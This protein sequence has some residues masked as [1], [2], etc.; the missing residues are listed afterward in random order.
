M[1]SS[2]AAADYL[3]V[4]SSDPTFVR[5]QALNAGAR[6][7]LMAG[8]T[9]TVM[10]AS[11]DVVTLKAAAG[12]ISLPQRVASAP[13]ADRMAVLRFILAPAPRENGPRPARTRGGICPSAEA[14]STLDAIAQVQ[15]GGCAD[16][17]AKALEVFLA[18]RLE[19]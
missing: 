18:S 5:G 12:G 15:Q 7:P 10:H 1:T 19:P 14:I 8:G 3:V 16:E 4:R 13:D 17:A 11:G 6:L 9:L 2:A